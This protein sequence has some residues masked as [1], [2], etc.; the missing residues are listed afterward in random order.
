MRN[1]A[2]LARREVASA[3]FSPLSYVVAAVFL[4]L[5]GAFFPYLADNA[6]SS[7]DLVD[8]IWNQPADWAAHQFL[9]LVQTLFMFA[10][11][12]LTI[13]V[14][15]EEHRSGSIEALLTA[16]V[17][18]AE[19]VVAKWAGVYVFFLFIM[20][21]TGVPMGFVF[22]YGSPD[23]WRVGAHYLGVAMLGAFFL[24]I[25]VFASALTRNAIV[26]GGVALLVIMGHSLTGLVDYYFGGR[27]GQFFKEMAPYSLLAQMEQGMVTPHQVVF[28]VS[29]TVFWLFMATRALESRKWRASP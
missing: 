25:G 29:M 7:S 6:S 1:L 5:T 15:S 16:P 10:A 2:P 17:T 4:V 12:L 26:A 8:Q 27:L 14:L 20:A 24:A 3:F 13:R 28:F 23:A 11:P 18:D 21:L 9:S 22:Y 19:V